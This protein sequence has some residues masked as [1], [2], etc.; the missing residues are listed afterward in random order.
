V[1]IVSAL[2]SRCTRHAS[3]N[4]AT[5]LR[6]KEF[7]SA[8]SGSPFSCSISFN[9]CLIYLQIAILHTLAKVPLVRD[10]VF[11]LLPSRLPVRQGLFNFTAPSYHSTVQRKRALQK[12]FSPIRYRPAWRCSV[13]LQP[14]KKHA[15]GCP[16]CHLSTRLVNRG[17]NG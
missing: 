5:S 2:L 6:V 4:I 15:D 12:S 9:A 11:N 10:S 8:C 14:P 1:S 7:P 3:F 16:I 17:E 13:S